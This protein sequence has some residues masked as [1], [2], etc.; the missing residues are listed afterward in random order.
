MLQKR[1]IGVGG[2]VITPEDKR[3]V[4]KVLDSNRLSYGP[5]TKRFEQEFAQL[6]DS[7]FAVFTNSGT[8]A[9]HIAIAAMKE[10][11]GWKDGDEILVPAVTFVATSNTVVYNNMKPVFVDVDPNSFNIDPKK[12]ERKINSKTR[13]I[14]VVHL[15]GLPA[16][17][18]PIMKIAKKHN[19][20]ILEDSCETMFAKYKERAVGSFG[21][22]GCF[23]TYIAHYIVTGIGG[24]NTTSDPKL[25]IMLRSLAN[26]GRDSIYL[27]IDDDATN[28]KKK[29]K[30]I[31]E[32]RFSFVRFGFSFRA[33]ELEAALGLSQ[34][35][36]KDSIINRR[37]QIAKM[38]LK[39]LSDLSN[40]IRFQIAPKGAEN[41]YMLFG[42]V[43]KGKEKDALVNY[44]EERGIETR[45]LL[46]LVNQ[47]V[48]KEDFKN[49]ERDYPVATEL[50]KSGFYIGC[51][52]YISNEDVAFIIKT[53]HDFFSMGN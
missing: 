37:K 10:K 26:H 53:F 22:I 28:D 29:L 44:L 21:D 23:S 19:L 33:T 50:S 38:Y 41:V 34:L 16:D 8:S 45:D 15:L 32:K 49:K 20:R 2:L 7:K 30:E 42:I 12:L 4:N 39:G 17:M 13:A 27:N 48:Y 35:K 46:P 1:E 6:H 9:L 40:Y 3:L 36:R 11:Y 24:L 43:C 52:Q 31:I 25:A 5:M 47:P 51:H 14:L 18:D